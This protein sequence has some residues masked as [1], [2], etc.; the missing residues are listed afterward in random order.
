V[1][2]DGGG[3]VRT[4]AVCQ[5]GAAAWRA[6]LLLPPYIP[7][8]HSNLSFVHCL[9]RQA[10]VKPATPDMVSS[11]LE[12]GVVLAAAGEPSF[13]E[14][15]EGVDGTEVREYRMRNRGRRDASGETH[16]LPSLPPFHNPSPPSKRDDERRAGMAGGAP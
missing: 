3:I 13:A 15:G 11:K 2:L 14:L 1:A 7:F 6:L 10:S 9:F 4:V 12:G 16:H 8:P 5:V